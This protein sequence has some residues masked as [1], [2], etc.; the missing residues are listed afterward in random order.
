MALRY[1]EAVLE[2]LRAVPVRDRAAIRTAL[3]YLAVLGPQ[4]RGGHSSAVSQSTLGLRE[5]RPRS[6]RCAWR[7]LY[8]Q[9]GPAMVVLAVVPEAQ[10]DTVGFRHGVVR[11]EQRLSAWPRGESD[12]RPF[13]EP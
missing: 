11:A 9:V 13:P 10:Q 4:L 12:D 1:H 6:G 5:L 2:E 8:R 3:G 7:V